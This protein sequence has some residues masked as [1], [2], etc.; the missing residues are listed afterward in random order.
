MDA[1]EARVRRLAAILTLTALALTAGAFQPTT[2]PSPADA[3][4]PPPVSHSYV[5]IR[6]A[7]AATDKLG[8]V[9]VVYRGGCVNRSPRTLRC[10]AWDRP[11]AGQ[12]AWG[13]GSVWKDGSHA[14]I[15]QW[16]RK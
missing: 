3:G 15:T 12:K 6:F 4:W 16:A 7:Q 14:R 10:D 9:M 13:H 5:S 2:G 11:T 8:T 1:K